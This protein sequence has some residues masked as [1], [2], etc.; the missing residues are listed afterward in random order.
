VEGVLKRLYFRIACAI[1]CALAGSA[2]LVLAVDASRWDDTLASGDLR[3]RGGPEGDLWQAAE[4][5]P[6]NLVRTTLGIQDD[7]AYRRAFQV[8]RLSHPEQPGV[9]D[10]NVVVFRNEATSD[11]TEIVQHAKDPQ[12]RAAAAN[13]LGVLSYSDAVYDY[14]NRGRM[15]ANASRRFQQSIAFDPGSADAKYNLELTLALAKGIGLTESG[16]GTNPSPGGK[17]S[18]GAGSGEPG[19][20]Y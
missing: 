10:P 18:K 5:A 15:I 4:L 9:S 7:L 17:G 6:G 11:L 19:S 16:G 14:T 1:A 12:R 8:F 20:G 3:Y 2:F 13:L